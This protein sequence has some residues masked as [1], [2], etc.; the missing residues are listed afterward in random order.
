MKYHSTSVAA[1]AVLA[2]AV[3]GCGSSGSSSTPQGASSAAAPPSSPATPVQPQP[4]PIIHTAEIII[5]NDDD[6][7]E[8]LLALMQDIED[9]ETI[10]IVA[11]GTKRRADV[12]FTCES[13]FDCKVTLSNDLGEIIAEFES[14]KM[15]GTTDPTVMVAAYFPPV[16]DPL[17]EMNPG[18][19]SAVALLQSGGLVPPAMNGNME[20]TI[21]GLRLEDIGADNIDMVSLTSNLDPNQSNHAPRGTRVMPN[22]NSNYGVIPARPGKGGS[23]VTA[24]MDNVT[25]NAETVAQAGWS[26]KVLFRD[27]GDT[28]GTG[29]GGFETGA[30]IYANMEAPTMQPFDDKLA[31]KFANRGVERW[32]TIR[33]VDGNAGDDGVLVNVPNPGWAVPAVNAVF[34][35]EGPQAAQVQIRVEPVT[36]A[37]LAFASRFEGTYFGAPGVFSCVSNEMGRLCVISRETT[38]STSFKITDMDPGTP[39][40]QARNGANVQGQWVFTPDD[41]AMVS[42]PDQDWIV[43]GGWATTPNV[44]GV[45]RVGAFFG[46]MEKYDYG[47]A[48]AD[49][50]GKATYSGSAA[51]AYVDQTAGVDGESGLFTARAMLEANFGTDKLSGRIDNFMNTAG[52]YLG[53][54]TA[55][56]P[57]DPQAGGENDWVVLLRPEMISMMSMDDAMM[58]P[59][60]SSVTGGKIGG[61]ADGVTWADGRWSAQLYGPGHRATTVMAPTGVAGRFRAWSGDAGDG[62]VRGVYGSF[63]AMN[64]N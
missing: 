7:Q 39:G 63:G 46:G 61:S 59:D 64:D 16:T 52:I 32:F 36:H 33:N 21:G 37:N 22:A 29:D 23:T 9:V 19:P 11:G 45:H 4:T 1:L 53:T 6:V 10:E 3:A 8:R 34:E 58:L 49:L 2:L 44:N 42:V 26:H 5:S 38:G 57:N 60:A 31:M 41:N 15:P 35:V 12:D 56:D 25:L 54:D 47:D 18:S 51:G 43:F 30:L 48:K 17:A 50:K 40:F 62:N 28:A 24:A 20:T 14:K 27:W 55:A 13:A